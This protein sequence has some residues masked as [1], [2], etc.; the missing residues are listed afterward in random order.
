MP[1]PL[2]TAWIKT[3]SPG[4]STRLR[5][6]RVV[7]GEEDLGDGRGLL[8]VEVRRD[9]HR[10]PL[11][12]DQPFGHPPAADDPEDAVADL[13]RPGHA[14][15]QRLDLARVLQPRDVGRHPRRRRVMPRACIRSARFSPHA[16][17][18]TRTWSPCGSG[19][20]TSR[21]SRTSGPPG[22]VMTTASH[23]PRFQ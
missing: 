19:A 3:R 7:R 4:R 11:G 17:T 1:T 21:T 9:R 22:F 14:R 15:P 2:P 6:E 20:G 13:E 23:F 8:E 18:R 5:L 10:H 16:R 12:R